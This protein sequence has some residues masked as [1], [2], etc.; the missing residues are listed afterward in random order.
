MTFLPAAGVVMILVGVASYYATRSLHGMSAFSGLNVALGALLL[1]LGGLA[2]ARRFRGFSGAES[3]R[4]VLRWV[5][6]LA[7]AVAA[8]IGVDVWARA[9]TARVDLTVDRQYTLSPE[10]LQ[11]CHELEAKGGPPVELVFFEDS[12]LAKDVRLLVEAYGAAC[13]RLEVR[14]ASRR[15]PPQ[16]A[17]DLYTTTATAVIACRSDACDPVGYPSERNITNALARFTRERAIRIYFTVGHGEIDLAGE[18]DTG[19]SGVA[20]LLRDEGFDPQAFVSP[21]AA[22]VPA[23][24]DVL[25]VAAPER[26]LMPEELAML[27]RYLGRGGRML[28]LA[29]AGQR[30][31]FYS[32]F[33]ARWGF[34]LDD[35]VVL[36]RASS[37]LLKDPKPVNLLVHQFAPYNPV[38][39]NLSPRTMLLLPRARPV[40]LGRKPMP[41]DKLDRAALASPRSWLSHDVAAALANGEPPPDSTEPQEIA[42]IATGRY[43]RGKSE[44][45]SSKEARIV[46]IGD[47]D[48]ASNRLLDALYNR[49]VFLNAVRWLGNDETRIA[50]SDKAW[51]PDQDPLTLQQTVAY[52]YFLAFALPEGLLLLGI[53]AWW[54]Q[55]T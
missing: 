32:E 24:A 38:T 39:R 31:N 26:D 36:D 29:D 35:A 13:K 16:A 28:V 34:T 23:D 8:V 18:S 50:L 51:T 19:Y 40:E 37:P 1:L 3:R 2:Q 54:R 10:T 11:L 46:V 48:F 5:A 30:S 41:D 20:A 45:D 21:A 9:L 7:A 52:F 22:E 17:R 12:L 14:D 15:A 53:F 55:R 47:R 43:P 44:E 49:D 27:D 4:V 42:L 6:I 33:L 25:V